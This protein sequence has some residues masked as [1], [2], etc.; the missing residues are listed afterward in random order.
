MGCRDV[1]VRK[2]VARARAKLRALLADLV[3]SRRSQ[4][5]THA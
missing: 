1:T 2:H 4:E 5:T 3:P